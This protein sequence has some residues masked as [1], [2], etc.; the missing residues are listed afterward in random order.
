ML[1]LH[2]FQFSSRSEQQARMKKGKQGGRPDFNG[3]GFFFHGI[4]LAQRTKGKTGCVIS[5]QSLCKKLMSLPRFRRLLLLDGFPAEKLIS[6][7]SHADLFVFTRSGDEWMNNQ[8]WFFWLNINFSTWSFPSFVGFHLSWI[9]WNK[10]IWARVWDYWKSFSALKK[11]GLRVEAFGY[12][13]TSS[14]NDRK[15]REKSNNIE[16]LS[17]TPSLIL[18]RRRHIIKSLP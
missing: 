16:K 14:M 1:P 18:R 11:W 10:L 12:Y 8:N 4:M 17:L 6:Y 7:C 5:L 2:F 13:S 15:K 3:S 9:N